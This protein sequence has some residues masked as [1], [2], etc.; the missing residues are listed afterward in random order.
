VVGASE[1][2]IFFG[3]SCYDY[4]RRFYDPAGV[5]FTTIDPLAENFPHQSPFVY[6]NN[7]PIRFIDFMGMNAQDPDKEKEQPQQQPQ[8][9]PQT[10]PQTGTTPQGEQGS[11]G[12]TKG[13]ATANGSVGLIS[14]SAA[15]AA[16]ETVKTVKAIQVAKAG[17]N[18]VSKIATGAGFAGL[19][20]TGTVAA[21]E[22]NAGTANT[23]T[24]A[25]VGVAI[26]VTIG[27]TALVTVGATGVAVGVV[28]FGAAYGI[29]SV[30]GLGDK[31]NSWTNDWGKKLIYGESQ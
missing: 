17:A 23:H 4:G 19:G 2:S 1:N 20:L 15:A 13:I 25:D 26:G 8:P 6:A 16:N 22:Y 29:A 24:I 28:G 21:I 18:L 12:L 10:Q 30:A 3:V 31:F 9:Q 14:V 5:H 27:A 11:E 7:N